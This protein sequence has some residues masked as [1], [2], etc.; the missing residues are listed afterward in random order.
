MPVNRLS[1]LYLFSYPYHISYLLG[2]SVHSMTDLSCICHY[3]STWAG[4]LSYAKANVCRAA[5]DNFKKSAIIFKFDFK[6]NPLKL[7]E[8]DQKFMYQI[9]LILLNLSKLFQDGYQPHVAMN[10]PISQSLVT[11]FFDHWR[12]PLQPDVLWWQPPALLMVTA[13]VEVRSVPWISFLCCLLFVSLNTLWLQT[14][15]VC[16]STVHI[17][18]D[19]LVA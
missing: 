14:W 5:L 8:M 2:T 6:E 11:P 12:V 18:C 16:V 17:A 10:P 9:L 3:F 7:I 13:G 15:I 19:V 1:L 4:S